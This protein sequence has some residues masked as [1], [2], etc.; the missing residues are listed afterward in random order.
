MLY[1]CGGCT[2]SSAR[3]ARSRTE[4]NC[5]SRL[6]LPRFPPIQE[7]GKG[8]LKGSAARSTEMAIGS[9]AMIDKWRRS[10]VL[11]LASSMRP[12]QG[13]QGIVSSSE[14]QFYSGAHRIAQS[15][16]PASN[17]SQDEQ[18]RQQVWYKRERRERQYERKRRIDLKRWNW[19]W[20][21]A[22]MGGPPFPFGRTTF[23]CDEIA[24]FIEEAG[25][26]LVQRCMITH[27]RPKDAD[28]V[29]VC[30]VETLE[31]GAVGGQSLICDR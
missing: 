26:G 12:H 29:C 24:A 23:D 18:P 19:P 22:W 11:C 16:S 5:A 15:H 6:I 10:K 28:I 14:R 3:A 13:H 25:L 30:R 17:C 1:R 9:P 20:L 8:W 27:P 4:A 31:H 21:R 7:H 2:Q